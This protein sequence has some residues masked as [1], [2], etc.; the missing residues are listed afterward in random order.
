MNII[1]AIRDALPL[2]R[3]RGSQQSACDD[4]CAVMV[5]ELDDGT[6]FAI[7]VRATDGSCRPATP[8]ELESAGFP[9][10]STIE[11]VISGQLTVCAWTQ[12]T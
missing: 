7:A 3:I 11:T 10:R 5:Q 6:G 1:E 4:G 12:W 2:A 9:Y 8:A